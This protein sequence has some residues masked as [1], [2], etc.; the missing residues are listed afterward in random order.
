MWRLQC[1]KP[2]CAKLYK[3]KYT[4][5]LHWGDSRMSRSIYINNLKFWV[6][7]K[8]SILLNVVS[9]IILPSTLETLV[10]TTVLWLYD[11][12]PE[13]FLTCYGGMWTYCKVFF[14]KNTNPWLP[15]AFWT[16]ALVRIGPMT[17]SAGTYHKRACQA[18]QLKQMVGHGAA[19]GR[20]S[21]STRSILSWAQ[22]QE[23]KQYQ[24]LLAWYIWFLWK[25]NHESKNHS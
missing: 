1:W 5:I 21:R 14:L 22:W 4:S 10:I 15:A 7:F 17:G 3:I 12:L 24:S 16:Y 6:Y 2:I 9:N 11:F 18:L 19:C 13:L 8:I 20:Y 23:D 25:M